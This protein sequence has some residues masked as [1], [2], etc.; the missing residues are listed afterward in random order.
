MRNSGVRPKIRGPHTLNL[1][2]GPCADNCPYIWPHMGNTY[3]FKKHTDNMYHW[4]WMSHVELLMRRCSERLEYMDH[5][6]FKQQ[7]SWS[8]HFGEFR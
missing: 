3:T 2:Q 4:A 8:T 1:E 6:P 5:I 7:D